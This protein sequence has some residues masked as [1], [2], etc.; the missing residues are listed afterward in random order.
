MATY[1]GG[2]QLEEAQ[3]ALTQHVVSCADGK[4]LA[5][6]TLGPCAAHEQAARV[7]SLSAHLPRRT[8]GA[9]RPE[10]SGARTAGSTSSWW[11]K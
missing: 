10:L 9:S 4:C 11:T 2:G 8:P 1:L 7:F 6:G 5:C 3:A